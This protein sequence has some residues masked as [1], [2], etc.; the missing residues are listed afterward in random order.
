V[1][2]LVIVPETVR[3]PVPDRVWSA[4]TDPVRVPVAEPVRESVARELKDEEGVKSLVPVLVEGG[5]C[6]PVLEAV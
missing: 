3:V 1:P 6:V 2:L 5:V 4:V